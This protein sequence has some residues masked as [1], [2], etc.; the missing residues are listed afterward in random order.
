MTRDEL[1]SKIKNTFTFVRTITPGADTT[2]LAWI[3]EQ[4]D[5]YVESL[6]P[7]K[8]VI[9]REWK[10]PIDDVHL[11]IARGYSFGESV[12]TVMF[13]LDIDEDDTELN[14]RFYRAVVNGY[15]VEPE[16][17]YYVLAPKEWWIDSNTKLFFGKR[18]DGIGI[19]RKPIGRNEYYEFTMDEIKEYKL[20]NFEREEV[21]EDG[22]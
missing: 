6:K 13:K 20:D 22:N 8:E 7:A 11:N 18:F 16:Q 3:M 14:E 1:I 12:D 2:W 5:E 19:D 21:D 17:R 4:V 10:K 9:P 15:T